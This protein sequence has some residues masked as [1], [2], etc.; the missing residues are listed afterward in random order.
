LKDSIA[1]TAG[2][3]AKEI[4]VGT[5][6][7]LYQ[8]P[9]EAPNGP[10][11]ESPLTVALRQQSGLT[12]LTALAF[13]VFTLIYTPCLGTVG[14]MLKETRSAKWTTFSVGYGLVLAWIL[15]WSVVAIAALATAFLVWRVVGPFV[16]GSPSSGCHGCSTPCALKTAAKRKPCATPATSVPIYRAE[17][18]AIERPR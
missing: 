8:A 14:M 9:A 15:S 2:F 6:G 13:M 1:L 4:V 7:V 18:P 17:S 12:P 16:R 10:A 11:V 5:M 3:V